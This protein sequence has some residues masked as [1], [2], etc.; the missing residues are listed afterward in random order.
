M[1]LLLDK[2]L[3]PFKVTLRLLSKLP[4]QQND[5]HHMFYNELS[6]LSVTQNRVRQLLG[7]MLIAMVQ[8]GLSGPGNYETD[9]VCH[10]CN[11]APRYDTAVSNRISTL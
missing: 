5:R 3:A 8:L 6:I 9:S 2:R 10:V 11:A 1:G 4:R 7:S